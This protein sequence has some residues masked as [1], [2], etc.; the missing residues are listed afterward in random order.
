MLSRVL[1]RA[2]RVWR[3]KIAGPTLRTY[4]AACE[5]LGGEPWRPVPDATDRWFL[6][7]RPKSFAGRVTPL[8]P[9][10]DTGTFDLRR[11]MSRTTKLGLAAAVL[12]VA[13]AVAC[14]AL[15]GGTARVA[16]DR[17]NAPVVTAPLAPTP[18]APTISAP[19]V[20]PAVAPIAAPA[21]APIAAPA[22]APIAA[23]AVAP[24]AAPAVVPIDPPAFARAP[25]FAKRHVAHRR[26]R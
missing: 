25:L 2:R 8:P 9:T 3:D 23:P 7:D 16:A 24:I 4:D 17:L 22:V 11:R 15:V 12:L 18:G 20:A 21:V 1:T 14:A 10:L 19:S 26:R 5:E 6:A 13:I